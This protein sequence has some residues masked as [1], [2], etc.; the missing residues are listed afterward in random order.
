MRE[1]LPVAAPPPTTTAHEDGPGSL[2]IVSTVEVSTMIKAPLEK[3]WAAAADLE[4]HVEWMTDAESITFLT[5]NRRGRGTR[6][7]VATRVGPF[8]TSD[9]MEV[10]EWIEHQRIG[11]RHR[12]LVTGEGAFELEAIDPGSTRFTWRERLTFPGYLGGPVTAWAASPVLAAVWKRNL[13]RLKEQL[14][15]RESRT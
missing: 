6:M 13:Q 1:E 4:S 11:V 8:R 2:L 9:I 3:V 15:H 7:Q 14:E 12:G 10:T 5:D